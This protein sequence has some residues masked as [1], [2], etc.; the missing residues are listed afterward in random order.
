VTHHDPKKGISMKISAYM[1]LTSLALPLCVTPLAQ[2]Q[3][4][5]ET[6]TIEVVSTSP[7]DG[8]EIEVNKI[9]AN[10]QTFRTSELAASP[11]LTLGDFLNE[12]LGSVGVSNA[13]GNPYQNDISYRGFQATSTLGAPVGLSVY[14]DGVRMNEP[15]GA[16]VNWEL[17]PMNA[18]ASVDVLP[19]SNP[20]FGLNTLGGALSLN[21]KNGKEHGGLRMSALTGSFQRR[22]W[23]L[24]NGWTDPAHDTDYF[25]SF[26][27][28]RNQGYRWHSA[29]EVQQAFGKA[30]WHDQTTQVEL[31]AV[32][33]H[34]ALSG[35]Q[36]LP[37]SMWGQ[38]RSAYTW[39]DQVANQMGLVNLE[40]R[41][42]LGSDSTLSANLYLRQSNSRSVNSNIEL[43]DDCDLTD[44]N[45]NC[46]PATPGTAANSW[47]ANALGLAR[48]SGD[49]QASLVR[50]NTRQT[51]RGLSVQ[52]SSDAP[53]GERDHQWIVGGVLEHSS[54]NYQQSSVLGRLLDYAVLETPNLSYSNPA[55]AGVQ[56]FNQ[57][58]AVGLGGQTRNLSLFLSDHLAFSPQWVANFSLSYNLSQLTQSG[59]RSQTLNG[60]G[61][62]SWS[63][64]DGVDYFNPAFLGSQTL[65]NGTLT[66]VDQAAVAGKTPGP[67]VNRLDGRY[68]FKRVNPALGFTHQLSPGLNVFAGYT[69]SM[70]A[71]TSI[72]LACADPGSPCALPTGFNGDPPLKA[73]VSHSFELGARGIWGDKGRWNAAVFVTRLS[74]D[75][76]FVTAPN[77]A[78]LGY[79]KNVGN[80]RRQGFELGISGHGQGLD[81]SANYGQVFATYQGSWTNPNGQEVQSGDKI[82]GIPSQSLKLRGNYRFA[83][84]WTV[85]AQTV[86]VGSQYAHGDEHNQ[87]PRVPGY[88]WVNLDIRHQINSEW[89]LT[90]VVQNAFNRT[91][92][93]YGLMATDIYTAQAQQ[94][95]KTPAPPRAIWVGIRWAMGPSPSNKP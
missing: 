71:P 65:D 79:F 30:R 12:Q 57:I 73:V 60:D 76:Q 24:E 95:F 2:A 6:P 64:A 82:P 91:Y 66:A 13:A 75:I 35:T 18:L 17:I 56:P 27:L 86:W 85:G 3:T 70:R 32:W 52:Y 61:S 74:D 90:A 21:T 89:A 36:A 68:V 11:A 54:V 77:S 37:P 10:V 80:T 47:P 38:P 53:W 88:S 7:I 93:T 46:R 16:I 39:P 48:Y 5:D 20:L 87:Y 23:Q 78:T 34:S 19:G 55:G 1:V 26:N 58:S 44:P 69:E 8:I 28:D 40:L 62:Y 22:A 67:E 43:G 45:L 25:M 72:E 94:L 14:L 41:R 15:F 33:A 51:T 63:G 84:D 50:S 81:W 29:S 59:Q 83:P 4:A 42:D 9:P 92:S 49:I 31:W